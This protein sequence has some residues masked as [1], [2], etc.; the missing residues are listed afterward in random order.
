MTIGL[1]ATIKVQP[2]KGPD[3]EAAFANQQKIVKD[4][5]PGCLQYDLFKSTT[6]DATYVVYEQY[7]DEAALK[8]HGKSDEARAGSKALGP[9][10]AG[11]PEIIRLTK[12]S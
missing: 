9:L 7:A 2:S 10:L 5:E 11:M 3:F 1:V 4:V 8:A 12:V 6:D